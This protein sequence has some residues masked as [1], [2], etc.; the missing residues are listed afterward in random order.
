VFV[1]LGLGSVIAS[2]IASLPWLVVISRHKG[3]VYLAVGIVLALDYWFIV[4][5]PQ[6][7]PCAPGE[8]CYVDSPAMRFSRYAFWTAVAIYVCAVSL[9]YGALLWLRLQG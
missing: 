5:R 6:R 7:M 2:T 3:W 9:G 8:V 4:V 1:S